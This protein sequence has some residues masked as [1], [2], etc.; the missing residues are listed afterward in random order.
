MY[1]LYFFKKNSARFSIHDAEKVRHAKMADRGTKPSHLPPK[2]RSLLDDSKARDFYPVT[3]RVIGGGVMM[4][5]YSM[6]STLVLNVL[7]THF[8]QDHLAR[9]SRPAAAPMAQVVS[10]LTTL[11]SRLLV[12][13]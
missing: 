1:F 13:S 10:W 11:N 4:G 5:G 3:W 12:S 7:L 2:P 8:P 6:C 9:R